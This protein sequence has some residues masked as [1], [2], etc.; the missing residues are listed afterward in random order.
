MSVPTSILDHLAND[1]TSLRAITDA[2]T[3]PLFVKDC[4]GRYLFVNAATCVVFGRPANEVLGRTEAELWPENAAMLQEHDQQV[5][6]T[7][8]RL[9]VEYVIHSGGVSRTFQS[10]KTP[11]LNETGDLVGLVGIAHETTEQ[12][13]AE[14]RLR[15]LLAL[16]QQVIDCAQEGIIVYDK[17]LRYLVWNPY[18]AQMTG[19]SSEYVLGKHPLDVFPWMKD[20]VETVHQRALRGESG[21]SPD[22][23]F[24]LESGKEGWSAGMW[25]PLR[26]PN[27]DIIGALGFVRNVTDRVQAQLKLREYNNRLLDVSRRL[28]TA[29]E[30]E[31]RHLARELHDEIGQVFTAVNLNLHALNAFVSDA[32]KPAL[33][34]CLQVVQR[35]I[36]DVRDL[37][38]N[39]R[40]SMLDDLGLEPAL[41]WFLDQQAQRGGFEYHLECQMTDAK[42]PND[43]E[44]ACFRIVQESL[45]NI[46]RYAH[47]KLVRVKVVQDS[48]MVQVEV[49][50]DGIGFATASAFSRASKGG[51]F[52]VLGMRERAEL[53]GGRFQL[54]SSPGQGTLIRVT[55][56]WQTEPAEVVG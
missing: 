2:I 26:D 16:N 11:L 9:T 12:N 10:T 22:M 3:D 33:Q 50:D 5:M 8:Q 51:S 46:A 35:A 14:Q 54:D 34:D 13:I 25:S 31:R 40:P 37:A 49:A 43:V 53:L 36:K 23:R 56:P 44:T 45:T 32:G 47:A 15:E 1:Q 38:I 18:M 52:G 21:E 20:V 39:L 24:D 7:K 41:R 42:L 4:E 28:L 30:Q 27:G 55:I 29:Q 6:Q 17:N 19:F 48:K